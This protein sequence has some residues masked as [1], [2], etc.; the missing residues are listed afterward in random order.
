M[1]MRPYAVFYSVFGQ[2]SFKLTLSRFDRGKR[3]YCKAMNKIQ[4]EQSM[5]K[6]YQM[7]IGSSK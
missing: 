2:L 3:I 1:N 7:K 4:K 5:S 6:T